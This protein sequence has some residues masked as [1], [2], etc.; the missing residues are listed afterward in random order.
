MEEWAWVLTTICVCMV[1]L[2]V[3]SL[4]QTLLIFKALQNLY[5]SKTLDVDLNEV[6]DH[7]PRLTFAQASKRLIP[8]IGACSYS[9]LQF[10]LPPC[11][12]CLL[13]LSFLSLLLLSAAVT[14]ELS[15]SSSGFNPSLTVLYALL[16]S[17]A[18]LGLLV[19]VEW[20][21]VRSINQKHR[22][23]TAT[24]YHTRQQMEDMEVVAAGEVGEEKEERQ[25][26]TFRN[27]QPIPA[28]SPPASSFPIL[29]V[30]LLLLLLILPTFAC[31][32]SIYTLPTFSPLPVL[33]Q[34]VFGVI[35]DIC[36]R[37]S[38]G[39]VLIYANILPDYQ[40]IY[41]RV[42]CGIRPEDLKRFIKRPIDAVEEISGAE[43]ADN[44]P[45]F[46][47][48]TEETQRQ[49]ST[50]SKP[51]YRHQV[52]QLDLTCTEDSA[53][54]ALPTPVSEREASS[55]GLSR[56]FSPA[57]PPLINRVKRGW[58]GAE[59]CPPPTAVQEHSYPVDEFPIPPEADRFS[60]IEKSPYDTQQTLVTPFT[61][62]PVSPKSAKP[63]DLAKAIYGYKPGL[64]G[65]GAPLQSVRKQR[66]G[67]PGGR[68]LESIVS[69]N[70]EDRDTE[71][72]KLGGNHSLSLVSIPKFAASPQAA[73]STRYQAPATPSPTSPAKVVQ[74]HPEPEIVL[75]DKPAFEPGK[76]LPPISCDP[77]LYLHIDS[78]TVAD[79]S[80]ISFLTSEKTT[81]RETLQHSLHPSRRNERDHSN[82]S[83][84]ARHD[85]QIM[86]GEG[87]ATE[88]RED[89]AKL[90]DDRKRATGLSLQKSLA[91]RSHTRIP[92]FHDSGSPYE[93]LLWK[94]MKNDDAPTAQRIEPLGGYR[95]SSRVK[96]LLAKYRESDKPKMQMTRHRS[97]SPLPQSSIR[98]FR[99]MSRHPSFQALP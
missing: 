56:E 46:T 2:S 50:W 27:T 66:K 16:N 40:R 45:P 98:P 42:E 37:L 25:E 74:F 59:P 12:H 70:E 86:L 13:M 82:S 64:F 60:D 29:L 14:E 22:E 19:L 15:P 31:L 8:M 65:K 28:A 34:W 30:S 71:A 39:G 94:M 99:T 4:R 33:S 44:C 97:L 78:P 76:P 75:P 89:L 47:T 67:K 38:L 72:R 90:R 20:A 35:L 21:F 55:A 96:T 61:P 51:A 1:L 53:E 91:T 24:H 87:E 77:D 85:L 62:A 92:K 23:R 69:E 26:L 88:T 79:E 43:I 5:Y 83:S 9:D 81:T 11:L 52:P 73:E 17:A 95:Q 6:A 58:E 54:A 18:G 84:L 48:I 68:V 10:D 93:E 80:P 63:T 57:F 32:W 3:V 36:M 7:L 49:I 41:R